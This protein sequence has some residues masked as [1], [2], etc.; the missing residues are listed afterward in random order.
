MNKRPVLFSSTCL[1]SFLGGGLAALIF[2]A[3][4]LFYDFFSGK[5]TGITN[6]LS[7][8]GTSRIYFLL[9]ALAHIISLSGV[10]ALWNFRRNGFY[11]YIFAQTAIVCLPLLFLGGKAFSV[12][13]AIFTLVFVS[14]YFFFYRWIPVNQQE[15]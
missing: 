1:L 12:T 4:A 5:V 11:A 13:N 8:E 14:I 9:M 10:I 3:V 6:E 2:F 15:E 7:M